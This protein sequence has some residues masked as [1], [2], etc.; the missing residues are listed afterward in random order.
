MN[1]FT[2]LY[3][4]FANLQIFGGER[5]VHPWEEEQKS[6]RYH[7]CSVHAVGF[8]ISR[9]SEFHEFKI[10]LMLFESRG[11]AGPQGQWQKEDGKEDGK[12]IIESRSPVT[13]CLL[14]AENA[15]LQSLF[16]CDCF[17]CWRDVWIEIVWKIFN[18][19]LESPKKLA[20]S[21]TLSST[22][23]IIVLIVFMS[24]CHIKFSIALV[25]RGL[26][27]EWQCEIY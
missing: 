2:Q 18:W 14:D 9:I 27:K 22:Q 3:N 19:K 23:S 11:I 20:C 26:Q 24:A 1:Q 15:F 21:A 25:H 4:Q 12:G 13:V 16:S 7:R 6:T 8:V 5:E 17:F 10:P